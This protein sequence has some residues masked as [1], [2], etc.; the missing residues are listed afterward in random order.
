MEEQRSL[1]T[2]IGQSGS[3][4]NQLFVLVHSAR[5]Q[6]LRVHEAWEHQKSEML[7]LRSPRTNLSISQ[8]LDMIETKF[9]CLQLLEFNSTYI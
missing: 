5:G 6:D 4:Y 8:L 2:Q 9:D 7:K 3:E 1:S